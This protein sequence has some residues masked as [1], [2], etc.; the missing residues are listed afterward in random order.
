MS[1]QP[2]EPKDPQKRTKPSTTRVVL[3]IAVAASGVYSI[4]QGIIGMIQRG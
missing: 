3:W 4:I 2:P 1:F